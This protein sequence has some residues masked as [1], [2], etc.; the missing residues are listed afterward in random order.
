MNRALNRARVVTSTHAT[1]FDLER[2]HGVSPDRVTVVPLGVD[3]ELF[4]PIE[5]GS[6]GSL[7]YF[8]HLS[9]DD[10]R[11]HT[12]AI[13]RAFARLVG[14]LREPVRLGVGGDLGASK[15][16]F[17]EHI[18]DLDLSANVEL[19]GRVTDERLAELYSG[20]VATVLACMDEGFGLQ[21][22]EAL[23]CGSLMVSTP[24]PATQEVAREADV[25]WTPLDVE[26][27]ATAFEAVYKDRLRQN[28][29]TATNRRA[30]SRF[31]WDA[32]AQ[33]LH[34]L[35][36]EMVGEAQQPREVHRRPIPRVAKKQ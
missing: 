10:P 12:L 33:Q 21:A 2:Y 20:A 4:R 6:D 29:A 13:I 11:E 3:L 5:R 17:V 9:S 27:M 30:A 36:S 25:E 7:P 35:L 14:R 18:R 16:T 15:R 19:T 31:S 8:F 22:L 1:V 28:R 23:A 34:E 24:A 26:H 32:T